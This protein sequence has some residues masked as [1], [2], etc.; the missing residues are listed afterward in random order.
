MVFKKKKS[1]LDVHEIGDI[2]FVKREQNLEIK[3]IS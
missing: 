2:I 1:I 3:T